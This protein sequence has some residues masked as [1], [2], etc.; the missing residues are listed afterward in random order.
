M[1]KNEVLNLASFIH[2]VESLKQQNMYIKQLQRKKDCL[3]LH[4]KFFPT[5]DYKERAS[6]NVDDAMVGP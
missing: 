5:R 3:L 6:E 4:P 2:C 1:C